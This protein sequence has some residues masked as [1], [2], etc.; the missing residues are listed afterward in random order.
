MV[1]TLLSEEDSGKYGGQY[2]AVESFTSKKVI[3]HDVDALK[4]C[5]QAKEIVDDPVIFFVPDPNVSYLFWR[6]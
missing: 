5:K 2:V 6:G 1:V 3:A 4:V